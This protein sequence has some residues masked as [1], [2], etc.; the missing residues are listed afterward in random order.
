MKALVVGATG[1]IGKECVLQLLQNS[2]YD[3]V[4]V[5]VRKSIGY[6]HA[7]LNEQIIDFSNIETIQISGINHIFCC[8]GTTI[9][10]AKNIEAYHKIDVDYVVQLAQLAEKNKVQKFVVIS[11]LGANKTSSNYYLK[12]KGEM[13]EAVSKC[14]IPSIIILRPSMLLGKRQEFRMGE[15]IG[16]AVMK[17]IGFVFIGK[18]KKYAGIKSSDVV[19]TMICL[20]NQNNSGV[21]VY[22]SDQIKN[23]AKGH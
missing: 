15:L 11:S 23:I 9:K 8:L 19:K 13:E 4:I 22:E 7:K 1:L 18:L 6:S 21:L 17:T 14:N 2:N 20:A 5:W 3:E 10:K 12:M 16:K